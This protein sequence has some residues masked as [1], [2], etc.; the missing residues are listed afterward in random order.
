[1]VSYKDRPWNPLNPKFVSNYVTRFHIHNHFTPNDRPGICIEADWISVTS[2][3]GSPICD[4]SLGVKLEINSQYNEFVEFHEIVQ[5]TREWNDNMPII[6]VKCP[7]TQNIEN[8]H[9]Y[10]WYVFEECRGID[11]VPNKNI[12]MNMEF[13]CVLA[14]METRIGNIQVGQVRTMQ[15]L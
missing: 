2:N 7:I 12:G 3:K 15:V 5:L 1:M 4:V 13:T 8:N 9:A 11:I 6:M 10:R 14:S